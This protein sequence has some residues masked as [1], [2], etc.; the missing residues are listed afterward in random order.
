MEIENGVYHDWDVLQVVFNATASS[1]S[2]PSSSSSSSASASSSLAGATE[3]SVLATELSVLATELSVLVETLC[4]K[5]IEG[6]LARLLP[7]KSLVEAS[8]LVNETSRENARSNLCAASVNGMELKRAK[9][10]HSLIAG[11]NE[12]SLMAMAQVPTLAQGKSCYVCDIA[13]F[14]LESFSSLIDGREVFL[15]VQG[16]PGVVVEWKNTPCSNALLE[17]AMYG[18]HLNHATGVTK[19][20]LFVVEGNSLDIYAQLFG[21]SNRIRLTPLLKNGTLKDFGRW[22]YAARHFVHTKRTNLVPLLPT[23]DQ[24]GP[25]EQLSPNTF[26]AGEYVFKVYDYRC[27]AHVVPQRKPNWHLVQR[28]YKASPEIVVKAENVFIFKTKVIAGAPGEK[29]HPRTATQLVQVCEQVAALHKDS[30]VH[31]DIRAANVLFGETEA[32]LIDFDFAGTDGTEH[33]PA[34]YVTK[35]LEVERHPDAVEGALITRE[36]DW[37]GFAECLRKCWLTKRACHNF[38][39]RFQAEELTKFVSGLND[40]DLVAA[41]EARTFR[42]TGS[43][44]KTPPKKK[45]GGDKLVASTTTAMASLQVSKHKDKKKNKQLC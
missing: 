2:A 4:C 12:S 21:P 5:T 17:A 6:N 38:P 27:R 19:L 3:L 26:R 30:L 11:N 32:F 7:I 28:F 10:Q 40:N 25:Y 36:H 14:P 39:S 23:F 29:H 13:V 15:P 8:Q 34:G 43:K 16:L 18:L 44:P 1:S 24:Q 41:D 31:G 33:Y 42:K 45:L 20:L 37:F 9:E 22:L 35:G